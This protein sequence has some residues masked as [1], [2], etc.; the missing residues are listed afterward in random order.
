MCVYTPSEC[1]LSNAVCPESIPW[2]VAV[3]KLLLESHVNQLPITP[4]VH[5]LLPG[6]LFLSQPDPEV[7]LHLAWASCDF[8]FSYFNKGN[9]QVVSSWLGLFFFFFYWDII[10]IEHVVSL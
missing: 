5:P 9:S 3:S 2:W 4:W 8:V 10:D 6:T 1:L 7:C